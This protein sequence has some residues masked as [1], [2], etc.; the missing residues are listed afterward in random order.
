LAAES[1]M[2]PDVDVPGDDVLGD[3]PGDGVLGDVF[4]D[5]VLGGDVPGDVPGD[6]GSREKD[7]SV[8]K[9]LSFS[10]LISTIII[11]S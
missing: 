8:I 7:K 5:D 1:D 10:N 6:D 9:Y 11:W 2:A 3:V 4:G